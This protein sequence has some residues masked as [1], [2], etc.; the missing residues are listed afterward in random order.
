M[1]LGR[2]ALALA[3]FCIMTSDASGAPM[4]ST[5]ATMTYHTIAI[6]G[7][8]VFYREAG[9]KDGP[10]LL[11]LHGFP[12]SSRMF[13]ALIPLLADRYHLVA[14]DYPGFGHSEAPTPAAFRYT[15]DHRRRS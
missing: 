5:R 6:D 14:P 12:S 9:P 13:D 10:I 3:A 11:L 2:F 15:F 1:T 8:E 4:P 7:L